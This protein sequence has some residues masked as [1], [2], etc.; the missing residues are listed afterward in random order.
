MLLCTSILFAGISFF[1]GESGAFAQEEE[2]NDNEKP[3]DAKVIEIT[4]DDYAF[5]PD[6]IRVPTDEPVKLKFINQ[7]DK[8]HEFMAGTGRKSH[9]FKTDLFAGVDVTKEKPDEETEHE[10]EHH[11]EEETGDKEH[12][13]EE[14]HEEHEMEEEHHEHSG[15][16]IE[17]ESGQTGSMEFTLPE[18]KK[19]TYRIACFEEAGE[20]K[21][22]ELGMTGVLIVE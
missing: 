15:T 11:E 18:S 6:T 5:T 3:G 21:H 9:G 19:G 13:H 7:G 16:M 22:F 8:E 14:E 20:E 1:I 2:M 17:L 10:E 4:M 12:A